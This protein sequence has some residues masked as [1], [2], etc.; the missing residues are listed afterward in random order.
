MIVG[1]YMVEWTERTENGISVR[2]AGWETA[3]DRDIALRHL[4]KKH[5]LERILRVY[6]LS[7][8]ELSRM[9]G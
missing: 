6:E 4:K 8:E 2:R 7:D 3:D 1:K 5:I 9:N